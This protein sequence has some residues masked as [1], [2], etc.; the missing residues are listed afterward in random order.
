[1]SSNHGTS[2]Q[3]STPRR[4]RTF[5]AVALA[6]AAVCLPGARPEPADAQDAAGTVLRI[7]CVAPRGSA[8]HRVFTAWGNSLRE[9]TGG[10]LSL[11]IQA[12][13]ASSNEADFVRRI[14]RDEL[15]GAALSALGFA[16]LGRAGTTERPV[17]V[18]QAPGLFTEYAPLDRARTALD[19]D[20][21]AGFQDAGVDLIGWSDLGR[22]RLFSTH[23]ISTPADLRAAHLWQPADEPLSAATL[24]QLGGAHP[25]ALPLGQVGAAINDHRVDTVV[26][27][28]MAVS[29]LN[30]AGQGRLTHVS[31]QPTSV[32]VGGTVI[33]SADI[34]AL[35]P[36]LQEHLRRTGTQAHETLQRTLRRDDDRAYE[37]LTTRGGVTPFTMGADAEWRTLATETRNRLV[38]SHVLPRALLDRAAR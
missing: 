29:A 7:A 23:P 22:G 1:M 4:A 2:S 32:L 14:Q 26:A 15:D 34:A 21:R 20:L 31:S 10:R 36:D 24:A 8:W 28:A 12:G 18:L 11:S 3:S 35:A 25:V 16:A 33:S 9:A 27:S 13:G 30:W 19:A 38:T 37:T 17:L 6:L 5:L